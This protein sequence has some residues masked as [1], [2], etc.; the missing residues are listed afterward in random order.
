MCQVYCI[1]EKV[2]FTCPVFP[3][4]LQSLYTVIYS[5]SI[6]RDTSTVDLTILHNTQYL[7]LLYV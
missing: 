1:V 6:W 7:N 2:R 5:H 3:E 4:T